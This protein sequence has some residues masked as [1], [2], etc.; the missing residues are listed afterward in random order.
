MKKVAILVLTSSK[1]DPEADEELANLLENMKG[2]KH[3]SIDKVIS[4]EA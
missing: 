3:W 4:G 1:N 2:M